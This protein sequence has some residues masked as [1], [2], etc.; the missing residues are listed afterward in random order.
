MKGDEKNL[1]C[2]KRCSNK[3]YKRSYDKDKYFAKKAYRVPTHNVTAM[4]EEILEK[5]VINVHITVYKDFNYY[6]R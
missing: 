3:N 2:A 5:G 6:K 4:Q 1:K